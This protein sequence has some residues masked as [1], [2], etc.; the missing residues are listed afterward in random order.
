MHRAS[1]Q[2]KAQQ[3]DSISDA[4]LLHAVLRGAPNAFD[5]LLRRYRA[6]LFRC[7]T[8]ITGRY[9]RVLCAQDID[10]IYAEV[11]LLLWCD[12]LRRLRAFDP[13]RGMKLGSWLG[14]LATHATY[15]YLRKL[16][17]R[18]P[19]DELDYAPERVVSDP[20]ALD[21]LIEGERRCQLAALTGEL[22]RR[23]RDF[24]ALYFAAD[25]SPEAVAQK[26]RI[27]VKTV[28]SK[29]N[30]ITT[31]LLARASEIQLAAA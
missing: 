21:R 28:Y 25:E 4:A 29:K 9:E 20:D 10:E 1:T 13:Q 30:K 5:A 8:R 27:S 26:L 23:D 11:C 31:R 24:V 14:L 18:P 19:H 7:I 3:A 16:A 15:D 2:P 22:S 17:R 6:L 12:D